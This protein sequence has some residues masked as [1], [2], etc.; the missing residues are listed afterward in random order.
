MADAERL[1][2]TCSDALQEQVSESTWKTFFSG[3]RPVAFTGDRLVL[4]V[5][6]LLVKERLEGR[7]LSLVEDTLAK[8]ARNFVLHGQDPRHD[9]EPWG[10]RVYYGT[11]GAAAHAVLTEARTRS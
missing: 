10:K 1:W 4:A 6:S 3:V 8:C 2:K 5:P 7:Y 9:M 11:A